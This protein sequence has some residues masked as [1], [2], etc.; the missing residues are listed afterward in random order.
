MHNIDTHVTLTV[1]D[2][3]P[4]SAIATELFQPVYQQ[5][6]IFPTVLASTL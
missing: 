3:L 2:P 6:S 1:Y 5:C 4:L